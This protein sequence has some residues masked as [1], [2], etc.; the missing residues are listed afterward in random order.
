MGEFQRCL[1]GGI[2][3]L[4]A[5]ED[6]EGGVKTYEQESGSGNRMDSAVIYLDRHPGNDGA[7]GDEREG[8]TEFSLKILCLICL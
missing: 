3:R 2:T 7:G 8:S 4:N 6:R 1:E 5:A